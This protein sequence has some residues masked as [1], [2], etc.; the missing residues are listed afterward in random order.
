MHRPRRSRRPGPLVAFALA[1]CFATTPARAQ[2]V[3]RLPEVIESVPAEY[4][5]EAEALGLEG[6]VVLEVDISAE[7]EVLDVR[8]VG[9][10]GN[11]FDEAAVEAV[12]AFRFLPAEIDGQPAAVTIEYRY[13]FELREKEPPPPAEGVLRGRVVDRDDGTPVAGALVDLGEA[14]IAETD[15]QGAFELVD[16]PAG[17]LRVLVYASGYERFE[18]EES[19]LAG[20]ATEVVY[21][22]VPSPTSPYETVV[23]GRREKKE[24]STVAISRGEITRIPGTYGDTVKVLHNLPSVARTPYGAGAIIVRGG[25]AHDTRAYVD[26]QYVPLIFHFGAL[27]SVYASELV[28]EVEFEAGNFGA[29]YGRAIGGRVELRTRD[30]GELHLVA[31]ADLYDATGLLETQVSD[32]IAVALAARRSYVDAMLKAATEVAPNAF[33]GMGFS[34]A[35]RFW[36]YQAKVAW[37]PGENDRLRLDVYGSSDRLAMTGV[38]NGVE[39]DASVD[40]FTGFTRVALAWDRRLDASTRTHLLL[41]PGWDE[42]GIAMDPLFFEL[43]A[44]S[45]TA[46]AEVYHDVSRHLSL[47]GGLDLLFAQQTLSIQLPVDEPGQIPPPDYRANLARLD[48]DVGVVQP[49]VWTEA[50]IRPFPALSLKPGLRLDGDTYMRTAWLDPRF[51]AR[52]QIDE[53]TVLEG[54]VGLYHQPPPPQTFVAEFGNPELDPEGAVQYALGVERRI[55]GPIHVD[56]Q[57]YYKDLFDLVVSSNRVVRRDGEDVLERYANE[58]TGQA[59]GVEILV[60]YDPDDRFFGWVGYS[61]SRSRRQDH[62]NDRRMPALSEQPH[63][64][65]AV[66]TLE[67]PEIWEGLSIGARLRY[68]SGNPY[69]PV[70]G[71]VY[72]ADRDRYRRIGE[73]QLRSLRLPDF[74]QLDLRVD[75]TWQLGTSALSLYLDVQNVTNRQ[76]AEGLLYN[77]DY[78]EHRPLPGLPIFPSMGIRWEM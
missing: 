26:G 57:V 21:H 71:G 62:L 37:R 51:S 30:P 69:T 13:R 50:E 8:V 2:V 72:D 11:G 3:T 56:L 20:Q 68:T 27:S 65:I 63:S 1:L 59:Y 9:P 52:L 29:R 78:S 23:R 16:L 17:T 48:L 18:T 76:N 12:R 38:D 7:G 25:E 41:A 24:V 4:P 33:E 60:R 14:G 40:T 46:R 5:P 34:V 19:I 32:G 61:L 15:A 53:A 22:L 42:I 67:L 35:P 44:L 36:D 49:A 43:D 58:G 73:A 77:F 28:E 6:E 10:A 66:G 75:K 39:T 70:V 47:A 45:L 55:W 74:F 31:D 54:A 64:L